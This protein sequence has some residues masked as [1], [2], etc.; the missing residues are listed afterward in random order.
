MRDDR[1]GPCVVGWR[2]SRTCVVFFVRMTCPF[3]LKRTAIPAKMAQERSGPHPTVTVSR[4]AV[5]GTPRSPSSRRSSRISSMAAARLFNDSSLVRPWPSI[6]AGDFGR[7]GDEP[8]LVLLHDCGEFVSHGSIVR[9]LSVKPSCADTSD[10]VRNEARNKQPRADPRK[11]RPG[12]GPHSP[13]SITMP[14]I[15]QIRVSASRPRSSASAGYTAGQTA[16]I[17]THKRRR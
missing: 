15:L 17:K 6:G 1:C 3:P 4:I 14:T 5:E 12:L 7:I 11:A 2:Y 16:V 9:F 13:M 10:D 8:A